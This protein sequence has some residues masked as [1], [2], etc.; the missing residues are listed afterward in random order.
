MGIDR[1]W[2]KSASNRFVETFILFYIIRSSTIVSSESWRSHAIFTLF[3]NQTRIIPID[4]SE[5]GDGNCVQDNLEFVTLNAK[6]YFVDLAGSERLARTRAVGERAREV[7]SINSGLLH[8]SNVISVLTNRTKKGNHVPYRD[9]KLTRVLQDSLGGKS[10]TVMIACISPC[11]T[12]FV[13]TLNTYRYANRT[14]NN[15]KKVVANQESHAQLVFS[16]RKQIL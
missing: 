16:L 7:I 11:D 2:Y 1:L 13:A 15:K 9:S 10:V 8:L 5:M 12:D 14:E 6:F 4:K 3:V